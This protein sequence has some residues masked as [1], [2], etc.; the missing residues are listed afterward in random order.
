MAEEIK[1]IGMIKKV[2]VPI[3]FSDWLIFQAHI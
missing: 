2:L 3:D 1:K